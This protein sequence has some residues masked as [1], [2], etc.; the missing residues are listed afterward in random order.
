[1][2]TV[3]VRNDA[4]RARAIDLIG[5]LNISRPWKITVQ[6]HKAKRSL[7][8]HRLYHMWVG[9]VASETGNTHDGI[10]EWAKG[11]FLPPVIVTV[12]GK[13]R[14]CRR[15]TTDLKTAEMTEYL[16]RF[17]AWA[18]SELGILLPH[19]EDRGRE[20]LKQSAADADNGAA[21]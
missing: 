3:I 20:S 11:E 6:P 15:S 21:A 10:H 19:P 4:L 17:S 9:V 2:F 1:M 12:N 14:E 8:Q 7:D 18:A 16:D 13:S 5:A